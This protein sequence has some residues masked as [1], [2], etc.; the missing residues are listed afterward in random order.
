MVFRLFFTQFLIFKMDSGNFMSRL[1]KKLHF[2]NNL[3]NGL[4]PRFYKG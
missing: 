1:S 2:F 4:S 3:L